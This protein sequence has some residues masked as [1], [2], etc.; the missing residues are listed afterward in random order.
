MVAPN[1]NQTI[2]P[3]Q[4][5]PPHSL[6]PLNQEESR[7]LS[8][9][10]RDFKEDLLAWSAA[11]NIAIDA[12]AKWLNHPKIAAYVS[13]LR[14]HQA[15][16]AKRKCIELL[17]Q[18]IDSDEP[19]PEKRRAATTLLRAIAPAGRAPSRRT[20]RDTGNEEPAPTRQSPATNQAHRGTNT[21]AAQ[22]ASTATTAQGQPSK[23]IAHAA[24]SNQH[25]AHQT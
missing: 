8:Q 16:A 12:L 3:T 20:P 6:E 25:H 15:Q 22:S 18:V 21:A 2:D 4:P 19:L 1:Q 24:T 10:F 14:H 9:F 23:H 5:P 11:T 13:A 17:E 7:F